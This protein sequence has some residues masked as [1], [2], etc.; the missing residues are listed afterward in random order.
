MSREPEGKYRISSA[1]MFTCALPTLEKR[2]VFPAA[3]GPTRRT[4]FALFFLPPPPAALTATLAPRFRAF[5]LGGEKKATRR[6][7]SRTQSET[8]MRIGDSDDAGAKRDKTSGAAGTGARSGDGAAVTAA[9][10]ES[11]IASSL[12]CLRVCGRREFSYREEVEEGALPCCRVR[13]V[14]PPVL[15][16][17]PRALI[18]PQN[19]S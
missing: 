5:F 13:A 19:S 11:A 7:T 2:A 8:K 10:I 16:N 14:L 15:F 1:Y 6:K 17:S 9:A 12:S 18:A 4:V 3:R